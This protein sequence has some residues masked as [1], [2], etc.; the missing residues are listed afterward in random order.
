MSLLRGALRTFFGLPGLFISSWGGRGWRLASALLC[1]GALL[2][3][4]QPAMAQYNKLP[5]V[6]WE[7]ASMTFY[8][9]VGPDGGCPSNGDFTSDGFC[10]Y[11]IRVYGTG[12]GTPDDTLAR[13]LA[14]RAGY[15]SG[16]PFACYSTPTWT[17]LGCEVQPYLNNGLGTCKSR[18]ETTSLPPDGGSCTAPGGETVSV[19]N[20]LFIKKICRT[21]GGTTDGID[22]DGATGECVCRNGVYVPQSD[23]CEPVRDR[24]IAKPCDACAGNPI[25]PAQGLK[26]QSLAVGWQPWTGL[27]LTYSTFTKLPYA[28]GSTRYLRGDPPTF[29]P[30]W[31]ASVDK[32]LNFSSSGNAVLIN[33]ARGGGNWTSFQNVGGDISPVGG[34]IQ[35]RLTAT[36]QGYRYRDADRM[37]LEDYDSRGQLLKITALDGRSLTVTRTDVA[38][39]T[40]TAQDVGLPLSLTDHFGRRWS[41]EYV[42]VGADQNS[43]VGAIV[44]PGLG[45][46]V[47]QYGANDQIGRIEWSDATAQQ[48]LYERSDLP[49]ALT[50]YN[51]ENNVRAGTYGYDA[52]GRAISTQRALG[53]DAYSVTWT[54]PPEM[55]VSE[56][57]DPTASVVWRDHVLQPAQ[58]VSLLQPNGQTQVLESASAFGTAKWITKAQVAGA[59]SPAATSQRALDANLNVTRLDDFNGNRSCMSYD[60]TR[61]LETSRV[62]GLATSADCAAAQGAVPTGARK[63]STQWHPDWSLAVKTAEPR[64]ITS[65]VYNGQPDP[66]N[67]GTVASCAPTDALLP[68]GKPIV[69]LCKRVEQ[70]TTDET[71]ALGFAATLQS[72]VAARTASWT[73]N[74]V[75]QVLTAKDST[76]RTTVTNEYY[77]DATT[78]H[79]KGDLKSSRNA[80]GHITSYSKYDAYGNVLEMT[81]ANN[82]LTTFVYDLRQRLKSVTTAGV[83]MS[84]SYLP[85]GPLQ[86][87]DQPDGSFVSYEYDDARRLVAVSDNLNNR[88]DYT[89]DASGN[90]T[91]ERTKDPQGLL[92][93]TMSR[94]YDAL[95]RAQQTTGRE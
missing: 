89:L 88:V 8:Y 39:V 75:G 82:V 9:A 83:T 16:N 69:V 22:Y 35:D 61:N 59:G 55:K 28:A 84:Y 87:V 1:L 46:T 68:D 51:D 10:S 45:R 49:W 34:E 32:S 70:A 85:T 57:Y 42:L 94:T 15:L 50:G 31:T 92:K 54:S 2:I 4:A 18:F 79:A 11:K 47:L 67:G 48:F 60:T 3:A 90:R 78:E 36:P 66:F 72:G 24:T 23:H 73:Y 26:S 52:A 56:W 20:F 81:D 86:R 80:V 53:L 58:G 27:N 30:M 13:A 6:K 76:G 38:T 91:Q 14:F 77:A 44:D 19:T 40:A 29:G 21:P 65:L 17:A 43:R 25:F 74:A 93:R 62:E 95:N 71:G 33:A 41:F 5:S 37:T 63:V 7:D 12:A 64:V